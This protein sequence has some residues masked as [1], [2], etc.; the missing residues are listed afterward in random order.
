[1]QEITIQRQGSYADNVVIPNDEA[2]S[3]GHHTIN[4]VVNDGLTQWIYACESDV[5]WTQA[6]FGLFFIG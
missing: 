3:N 2:T 4:L 6:N 5:A 1:M